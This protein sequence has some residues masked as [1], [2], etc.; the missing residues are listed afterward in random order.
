MRRALV[1]VVVAVMGCRAQ[2]SQTELPTSDVPLQLVNRLCSDS[3]AIGE[4]VP[5][6]VMAGNTAGGL[7][8]QVALRGI[9]LASGIFRFEVVRLMALSSDMTVHAPAVSVAGDAERLPAGRVCVRARA[10]L[11][12]KIADEVVRFPRDP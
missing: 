9:D 12:A 1:I 7:F 4:V 6:R 3:A 11:Q 8:A 5:A 2:I 10:R